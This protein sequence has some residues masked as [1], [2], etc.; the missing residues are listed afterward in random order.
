MMVRLAPGAWA[1]PSAIVRAGGSLRSRSRGHRGDEETLGLGQS[2]LGA[3]VILG[4]DGHDEI[5]GA[6]RLRIADEQARF[7]K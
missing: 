2:A 4:A 6:R 7:G 3:V 5:V 1:I